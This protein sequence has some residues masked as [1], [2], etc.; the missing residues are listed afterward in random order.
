L[1]V[2]PF[3]FKPVLRVNPFTFKRYSPV[4]PR[5][6]EALKTRKIINKK[7]YKGLR[8]WINPQKSRKKQEISNRH[9]LGVAQGRKQDG[10]EIW[11]CLRPFGP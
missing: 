9:F 10:A 5:A 2:N 3:T 11:F 1:R 8:L 7:A 4:I 6:T